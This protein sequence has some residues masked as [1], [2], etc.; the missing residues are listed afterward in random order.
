[1]TYA[2]RPENVVRPIEPWPH[3]WEEPVRLFTS[4]LNASNLAQRT[5]DGY[6]SIIRR[7]AI[8]TQ[9]PPCDVTRNDLLAR[10]TRGIA[11]SSMATERIAYRRFFGLLHDDDLIA[12]DPAAKLPRVK[13]RKGQPRPMTDQ[14][15]AALFVGARR[16]T[17]ALLILLAYVGMRCHEA[18]RVRGE[19]F[20]LVDNTVRYIT[21]GGYERVQ[22]LHPIVRALAEQMPPRGYWFPSPN[23]TGPILAKTVSTRVG[24]RIKAAGI[25][26]PKITAHSIRHWFG[27][28]LARGGADIRVIQTLM[29]HELISSTQIYVQVDQAPKITALDGLP[30]IAAPAITALAGAPRLPQIED[31][32]RQRD[33][34]IAHGTRRKYG[35]GCRCDECRADHRER[36][37]RWRE[38]RTSMEA[39]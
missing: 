6:L 15:I 33:A 2:G 8:E 20:D 18:A 31:Q 7:L 32:R 24:I 29:G 38:N 21:K 35:Q 14:Q 23:G 4:T 12:T 13:V 10:Q 1:M 30:L 5:V 37:A 25:D 36:A 34:A 26:D 19:M 11:A 3:G 9:K 16:R 17:Q 27:T 22:P 39:V 28:S